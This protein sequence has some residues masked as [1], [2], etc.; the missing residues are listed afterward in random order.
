MPPAAIAPLV[1]RRRQ[2][3]DARTARPPRSGDQA[4]GARRRHRLSRRPRPRAS[5]QIVVGEATVCLPLGSLIDLAAEARG[6]RRKSPRSP[7]RSPASQE[8][9]QRK[10]VANARTKSSR[11]SA[12]NSPNTRRR[13]SACRPPCRGCAT[14]A[15]SSS[16]IGCFFRNF[17]GQAVPIRCGAA[18]L[19]RWQGA[20]GCSIFRRNVAVKRQPRP[21][22]KF[23]TNSI[24]YLAI[25]GSRLAGRHMLRVPF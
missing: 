11:P 14:T 10:F 3:R 6:C 4:A 2:R 21:S 22:L 7:R 25:A 19:H 13:R 12:K 20:I 17:R 24:D 8:A 18:G 5:A 23:Q 16:A 1:V 15:E 9:L